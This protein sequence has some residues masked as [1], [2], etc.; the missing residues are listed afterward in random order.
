MYIFKWG[1]FLA[2]LGGF[3]R[4]CVCFSFMLSIYCFFIARF[5]KST[6]S[7]LQTYVYIICINNSYICIYRIQKCTTFIFNKR[8]GNTKLR[9]PAYVVKNSKIAIEKTTKVTT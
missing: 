9:A 8:A 6:L 1:F 4:F 7:K 3:Y 5:P 2:F